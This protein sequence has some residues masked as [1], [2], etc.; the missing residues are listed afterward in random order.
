MVPLTPLKLSGCIGSR[1][2]YLGLGFYP[3]FFSCFPSGIGAA[4]PA[5]GELSSTR[6]LL[7]F[8]FFGNLKLQFLHLTW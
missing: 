7:H 6:T 3:A 1:G 4:A 8:F 2:F 5:K